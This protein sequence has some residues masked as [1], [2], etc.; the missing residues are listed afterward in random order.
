M[1]VL[2]AYDDKTTIAW[3]AGCEFEFYGLRNRNSQPEHMVIVRDK[4]YIIT[5]SL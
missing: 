1:L 3:G 4:L 5:Y 2:E